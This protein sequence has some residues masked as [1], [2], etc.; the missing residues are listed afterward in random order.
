MADKTNAWLSLKDHPIFIVLGFCAATAAATAAVY[1][2]LV[3]P[4]Q[5]KVLE[6]QVA[7]FTRQLASM[8]NTEKM[9]AEKDA[10][11]AKLREEIASLKQRSLELTKENIFSADDVYPKAFRRVRI[12]DLFS[13]LEENYPG[14]VSKADP[15]DTYATYA[16]LK[17]D[18]FFFSSVTYFYD[19]MSKPHR[20]TQILFHLN[21][22][23]SP[24]ELSKAPNPATINQLLDEG[25]RG[26]AGALKTQLTERY[27]L[28]KAG[29]RETTWKV[30]G[31]L[32][33]LKDKG[34]LL[35]EK[36]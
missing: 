3:I 25:S 11:I 13:K 15:D 35:I 12:G 21:S 2:K 16:T 5:V 33:T 17:I 34:P 14:M 29:K 18:D 27:G 22:G 19:D 6:V 26:Y 9:V 24:Q 20:V 8:P 30:K 36:P 1:V 7:D 32:V 31:L 10:S 23:I 4:Y 28:G